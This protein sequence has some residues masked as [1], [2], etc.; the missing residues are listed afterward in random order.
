MKKLGKK[1]K[2]TKQ[3]VVAF[4]CAAKCAAAC[5]SCA[6]Y[7]PGGGGASQRGAARAA[8]YNVAGASI[9]KL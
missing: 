1:F 5:V 2:S 9:S 3:S 6:C 7:C 8:S 4:S